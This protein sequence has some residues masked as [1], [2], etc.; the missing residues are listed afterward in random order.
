ME[1]KM[2]LFFDFNLTTPSSLDFLERYMKVLKTDN[3]TYMLARYLLE[4]ALIDYN[5]IK[6]SPSNIACASL[7][8]ASKV[9]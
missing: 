7:Y 4:L 8:L 5:V 1:S 2:L 3:K 6:Y 9:L